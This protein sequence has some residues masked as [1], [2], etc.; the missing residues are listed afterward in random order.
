M[1]ALKIVFVLDFNH[2]LRHHRTSK[3]LK[4]QIARIK[5]I[6]FCV[7]M[8]YFVNSNKFIYHKINK[9]TNNDYM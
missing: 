3:I 9:I 6:F 7:K 1:C 5:V 4:L 8:M 2:I